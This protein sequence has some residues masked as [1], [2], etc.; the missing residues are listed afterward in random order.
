MNGLEIKLLNFEKALI[1]LK[2]AVEESKK[3]E[4][5]DIIRDGMIQRFEL[6]FEL[7]WKATKEY[8]EDLGITDKNSPKVA[9][10]EAFAQNLIENQDVW[11]LMINDRNLTAHVYN[12]ETAV[13][14]GN[15]IKNTYLLAF[16][17][18][19]IELKNEK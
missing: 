5:S 1:K 11:I 18:L 17:M 16:E 8:L 3:N 2:E 10:R 15:R 19:L 12:E 13:E 14:I 7:A 9:M 6:T 4:V